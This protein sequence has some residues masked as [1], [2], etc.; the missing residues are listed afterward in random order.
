M[1]DAPARNASKAEWAEFLGYP[2]DTDKTRDDL[3]AEYDAAQTPPP[4]AEEGGT[5][6]SG[7]ISAT[8][9]FGVLAGDGDPIDN[10]STQGFTVL[11]E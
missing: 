2:E 8:P 7:L 10:D 4:P 11:A 9:A 3:I 1:A 6:T 5:I